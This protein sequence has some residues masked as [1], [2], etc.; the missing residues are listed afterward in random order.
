MDDPSIPEAKFTCST[1]R[2]GIVQNG[3]VLHQTVL[4][5]CPK[6]ARLLHNDLHFGRERRNLGLH[7]LI[8]PPIDG[9]SDELIL[10]LTPNQPGN[11][12]GVVLD[13][14][15]KHVFVVKTS[16]IITTHAEKCSEAHIDCM[17][18]IN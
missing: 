14:V 16:E 18:Y 3:I 6:R 1:V 4:W 7:L 12:T 2:D 5:P 11:L 9:V 17:A 13:Q 10:R 15:A 8:K